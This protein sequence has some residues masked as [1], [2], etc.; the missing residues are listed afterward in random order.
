MI[1][2][3]QPNLQN[4]LPKPAVPSKFLDSKTGEVRVD[5]LAQSY[6]ELEKRL[7]APATSNLLADGAAAPPS[8]PDQYAI[9]IRDARV[10]NDP[11]L[12]AKLHAAGF[13]NDQ[14]QLI[15]DLIADEVLP[16]IEEIAG[17]LETAQHTARLI[18]HFGDETRWTEMK[19]QIGQWGRTNL[20]PEVFAAL[21][22]RADGVIAMAKMMEGGEPT[23][24][25]AAAGPTEKLTEGRLAEMVRDPRYWRDKDPAFID[26]VM[27]GYEKLFPS[28]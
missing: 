2:Q 8:T 28:R 21:A 23:L 17:Q 6:L 25:S 22:G 13:T 1:T 5:A 16:A 20:S 26:T 12:N 15:Y 14:V 19:R 4:P 3:P 7:G 9:T 27:Q 18:H 10:Q 11:E 24:G